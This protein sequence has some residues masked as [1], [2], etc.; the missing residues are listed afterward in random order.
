VI[1][2]PLAVIAGGL[3]LAWKRRQRAAGE[4]GGA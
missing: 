1:I 4:K 3:C 2:I